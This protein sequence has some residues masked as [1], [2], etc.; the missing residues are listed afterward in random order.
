MQ[1]LKKSEKSGGDPENSEKI[2]II[3][4]KSYNLW[5]QS[6]S[7]SVTCSI[8]INSFFHSTS[9]SAVCARVYVALS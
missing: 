2:M 4:L 5:N 7:A 9:Y 1:N 3:T 8:G 6:R